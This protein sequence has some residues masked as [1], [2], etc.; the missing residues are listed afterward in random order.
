MSLD[1]ALARKNMVQS[2]VVPHMVTDPALL[3]VL[4]TLPRERF[5]DAPY[6]PF[7]YSDYPIPLGPSGRISLL[8]IQFAKM[9][10]A[11]ACNKGEKVLVVGAGTGYEASLLAGMGLQVFAL[12]SDPDLAAQGQKATTGTSITWKIRDLKEGCPEDAPFDG[13]LFCGAV[14]EIPAPC[15][16]QLAHSGNL[17]AIVGR[18]HNPVMPVKRISGSGG[19]EETLFETVASPLPGLDLP[20]PFEI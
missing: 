19:P 3:A 17:V 15:R 6:Q 2:Q 5:L 11:L 4:H 10:Q 9:I 16:R 14:S 18:A 8:P 12:E 20:E 13:I 1:L 7:A